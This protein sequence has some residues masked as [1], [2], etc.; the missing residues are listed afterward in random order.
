[1]VWFETILVVLTLLTG[2]EQALSGNDNL[3]IVRSQT[4]HELDARLRPY[5][6][7]S[8]ERRYRRANLDDLSSGCR[9]AAVSEKNHP[10]IPVICES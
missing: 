10:M 3:K 5:G 7:A 9:C 4:G 6:S 2:V 1:M 8:D